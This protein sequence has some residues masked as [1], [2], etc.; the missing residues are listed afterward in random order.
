MARKAKHPKSRKLVARGVRTHNLKN[1]RFTVPVGKLT[2]VTGVSGSGKSSLALDTLFAEGKRRYVES[3]SAYARQFLAKL[4]RPDVDFISHIPPAIA[5]R[6]AN[7]VKNARS[8][9]GTATEIHDYLRLVFARIGETTCLSCGARVTRVSPAEAYGH[10]KKRFAGNEKVTLVAPVQ[11]GAGEAPGELVARLR[12]R[13]AVRALAG[14]RIVLLNEA[15]PDRLVSSGVLSVVVDRI[16]SGKT[17]SDRAAESVANAYAL[18]QR[19]IALG[20][21]EGKLFL[22]EQFGCL[23]CGRGASEPTPLLFSF[24]SPGGACPACEG[25][26][27]IAAVDMDRVIPD[28]NLSLADGAIRIWESAAY[29]NWIPTLRRFAKRNKIPWRRP[30][31]RLTAEHK[32]LIEEG[33][34]GFPGILGFFEY[35][36]RKRYKV[37]VRVFIARHRRFDTCPS[38]GGARLVP[39]ALAVKVGGAHIAQLARMPI[40]ELRA[41]FENLDLS[42]ARRAVAGEIIDEVISRAR[43]LEEVGLSYLALSRQMR[44]L[45]AGEAQRINLAAALGSA[46]SGVLYI[47]DEPTVGLHARDT[48]RLIDTLR[49]LVDKANTVLAIEHDVRLIRASNHVID[50]G[51]GGGEHGGRV[52]YQGLP[53]NLTGKNTPTGRALASAYRAVPPKKRRRGR[54]GLTIR[55]ARTHNLKN[56]TVRIPLNRFVCVT[57]VSGSGKSSLIT[58][59]LWAAYRRGL[60]DCSLDAPQLKALEGADSLDEIVLVDPQPLA[61]SRRSNIATQMGAYGKIRSLLAASS[62]RTPRDFSFNVPGG[63]CEHCSGMGTLEVDMVFM[64]NVTTVCETCR[65]KRFKDKILKVRF[66]GKGILDILDMTVGEAIEFF[67]D[68]SAVTRTLAPLAAIGLGYI[69]LGQSTDTLSGGEAARLKLAGYLKAKKRKDKVLFLFDEP[70]TGLHPA[71]IEVFLN[72]IDRL[73]TEGHSVVVIEHNLAVLARADHIIDLGPE[74]GPLGGRIVGRGAP[75]AIAQ[76]STPTARALAAYL[77]EGMSQPL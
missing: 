54:G 24:N 22:S 38:C 21:H 63:R 17:S 42:P 37:H 72:V 16:R 2:V 52:L 9:V 76:K 41:F 14:G 4:E 27:R 39:E 29:R 53:E 5:I 70:T 60:G 13:G 8:T 35:L 51:P 3:L 62:G 49:R 48:G 36:K 66:R 20:E 43:F 73:I 7:D 67:A 33:D 11:K 61:K 65:G 58:D 56:V 18:S 34:E 23:G 64:A 69:R 59:T 15:E 40:P 1:I 71:D 32:R 68:T 30:Y 10:I 12:A 26:G 19:A 6:H 31:K 74:G 28:K 46:L 25:F 45:S 47:L 75:Q 77:S 55:G 50:L 44:T 57:G